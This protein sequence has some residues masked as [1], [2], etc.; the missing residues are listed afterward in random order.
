MGR[1][2]LNERGIGVFNCNIRAYPGRI[3]RGF[4]VGL[5]F[6]TGEVL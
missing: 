3:Y 4:S 2:F 6:R 5:S 1:M